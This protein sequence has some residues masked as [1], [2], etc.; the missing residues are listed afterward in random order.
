MSY[1]DDTQVIGFTTHTAQDSKKKTWSRK[2]FQRNSMYLALK[3]GNLPLVH[4]LLKQGASLNFTDRQGQFPAHLAA[5]SGNI[6]L[7]EILAS[8]GGDLS[9]KDLF[10]YTPFH[11]AALAGRT[12]IIKWLYERGG[13]FTKET[14]WAGWTALHVAAMN[15]HYDTSLQL[16]QLGANVNAKDKDG[17]TPSYL[18]KLYNRTE[19]L[20]L[21]ES[22]SG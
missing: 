21:L 2:R 7:L 18:A 19:V 16:L 8:W 10:G 12:E 9:R 6:E 1:S 14:S 5:A 22:W 3:D 20:K 17:W 4:L 11:R 13:G 15:G